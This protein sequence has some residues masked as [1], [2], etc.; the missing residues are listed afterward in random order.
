MAISF[1]K[2]AVLF[3]LQSLMPVK[4]RANTKG[5]A[6]NEPAVAKQQILW[7]NMLL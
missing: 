7:G 5:T 2:Q 3:C 6:G 4:P 1:R